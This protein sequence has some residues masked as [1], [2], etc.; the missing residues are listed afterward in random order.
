[1]LIDIGG[2]LLVNT[3]YMRFY[4]P[5]AVLLN[6]SLLLCHTKFTGTKLQT[7][8]RSEIPSLSGSGSQRTILRSA[9]KYL[10]VTM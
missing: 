6:S 1:L 5:K 8:Q 9:C 7:F 10:Q 4:V 3:H 2:I